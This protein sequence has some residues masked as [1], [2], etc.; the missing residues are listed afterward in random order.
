VTAPDPLDYTRAFH[1]RIPF[2]R[3]LGIAI[4]SLEPGRARLRLA[5]AP[6]LTNSFGGAHGGAIA[7]L[8]DVAA[9]TATRTLHPGS[10][11]VITIDLTTSFLEAGKGALVAEARVLRD[12]R[13]AVFVE[14]EVRNPDG[15]LVAKSLATCRAIEAG[16]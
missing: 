13:S 12:G 5:L 16:G 10:R 15:T 3:H 6:E 8:I 2:I 7:T 9:T 14:A 1:E 4:E 11:G